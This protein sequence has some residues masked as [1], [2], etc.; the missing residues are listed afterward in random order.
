MTQADNVR[1][2]KQLMKEGLRQIYLT[3]HCGPISSFPIVAEE[4]Y[5]TIEDSSNNI[6]GLG[7]RKR[8]KADN[9][10]GSKTTLK[11]Q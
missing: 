5:T 2:D 11:R 9:I 4:N 1:T 6:I 8:K 3:T 10:I 7:K